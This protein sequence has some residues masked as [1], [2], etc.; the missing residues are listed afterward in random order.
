MLFLFQT[1]SN[2]AHLWADGA[3]HP[4]VVCQPLSDQNHL[5]DGHQPASVLLGQKAKQGKC[6]CWW[7]GA[8]VQRL[9]LNNP[10][11]NRFFCFARSSRFFQAKLG[12]A[13]SLEEI[14]MDLTEHGGAKIN[15]LGDA[16][17]KNNLITASN[18]SL[19]STGNYFISLLCP[20]FYKKYYHFRCYLRSE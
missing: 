3:S 1:D 14:A 17:L 18:G 6:L 4:H 9:I 12:T 16:G 10:S 7:S 19:V 5:G 20:C 15:R 2:Q 8:A 11:S 13:R